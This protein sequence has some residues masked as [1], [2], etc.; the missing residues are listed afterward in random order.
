MTAIAVIV[1]AGSG[2]RFG[3]SA[4]VM[5]PLLDRPMLAWTLDAFAKS[6]LTTG[7]VIVVGRHT[8]AAVTELVACGKWPSVAAI[9]A[10]GN[11]RQ[12][13]MAN[14]VAAVTQGT[15]VVLVHDAARPLV[16]PDQIDA[17]IIAAAEY[18]GAILAAPITDTVKRVD[19]GLITAT[20]D[21]STLW[22]AQT[23]QAFRADLIRPMAELAASGAIG[24]TDE[25][26]LAE[27]L[28]YPVHIV[29]SDSTNMKITHSHDCLIAEAILRARKEQP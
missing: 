21:R 16:Q 3:D 10:G 22:A 24:I 26:S 15:D 11:S 19:D 18:G 28:G 27:R 2:E 13:S 9:V 5:A 4:K 29:A 1:A 6:S 12:Y 20:I 17:C 7:I 23:P 14:G 8:E 25:A